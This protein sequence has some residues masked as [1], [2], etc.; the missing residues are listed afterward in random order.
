MQDKQFSFVLKGSGHVLQSLYNPI[1]FGLIHRSKRGCG[2][3]LWAT[4]ASDA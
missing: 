2:V 4:K 3:V 1:T